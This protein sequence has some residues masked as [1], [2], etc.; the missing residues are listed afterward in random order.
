MPLC[1]WPFSSYFI[2]SW[3]RAYRLNE[4]YIYHR[5]SVPLVL[6]HGV[7]AGRSGRGRAATLLV[8]RLYN[9]SGNEEPWTQVSIHVMSRTMIE[10]L[11]PHLS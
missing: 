3:N 6:C 5:E 2:A 7:R 4:L 9:A 10:H 11:F 8:S 1:R